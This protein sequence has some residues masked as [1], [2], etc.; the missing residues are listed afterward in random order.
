MRETNG[1]QCTGIWVFQPLLAG[2]QKGTDNPGKLVALLGFVYLVLTSWLGSLCK[3][4][5]NPT[6]SKLH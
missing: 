5:I 2:Q 3:R 4:L 1:L 6:K